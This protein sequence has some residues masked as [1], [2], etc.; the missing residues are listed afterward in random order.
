MDMLW[1]SRLRNMTS[2]FRESLVQFDGF[3]NS[4]VMQTTVRGQCQGRRSRN[5]LLEPGG[6]YQRGGHSRAC[7]KRSDGPPICSHGGC[8]HTHSRLQNAIP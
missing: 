3:L 2:E 5:S 7:C 4:L 8:I 6:C 1:P